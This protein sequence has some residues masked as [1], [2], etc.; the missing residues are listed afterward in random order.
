MWPA[1]DAAGARTREAPRMLGLLFGGSPARRARVPA[2]DGAPYLTD[3]RR[4][5]RVVS[6][7]I[8]GSEM[9]FASLEDCLTLKVRPY[10]PDELY[11]MGLRR[12]RPLPDPV[13]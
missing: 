11:A 5:F 12:V 6:P 3:G 1:R 8:P 9:P 4:L 10:S 7:F 2:I 13:V